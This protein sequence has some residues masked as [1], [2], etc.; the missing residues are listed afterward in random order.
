M[1]GGAKDLCARALKAARSAGAGEAA[2][3]LSER[4]EGH[5]RF[6]DN[7][8]TTSAEVQRSTLSLWAAAG[9]RHASGSTGDLSSAGILRLTEEVVAR[10]RMSPEDPEYVPEAPAQI[11]PPIPSFD[12]EAASMGPAAR[13]ALV[14]PVLDTAVQGSLVAAGLLRDEIVEEMRLSTTGSSGSRR[15]TR[16]ELSATLRRRD[17]SASGWAGAAGVRLS[18]VD[19]H[20]IAARAAQKASAWREPRELPPGPYTVVLEP[21]A[22]GPLF[23]AL[24]MSLD[25]RSAEE[26][27]SAFS[28]PGGKSRVGEALFSPAVTLVSD[29]QDPMVPGTPWSEGGLAARRVGYVQAGVLRELQRSRYWA[30]RTGISPTAD[31]GTL[32]L[33]GGGLSL[34]ELVGKVDRGLLVTRI[35]YVRML[36]P[37]RI[38]VTGLTRD[39]TF[40]IEGGRATAAVKNFRFNQSLLDLLRDVVALGR[41]EAALGGELSG[42]MALPPV[43]V[44]DFHMSSVSEAV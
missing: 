33:V 2:T 11:Y 39:A 18:D 29:P 25:A 9:L 32:R 30:R 22:L 42:G 6:A 19:P 16:V 44:K 31:G 36:D 8:P 12:A 1:R 4:R 17:G 34:E 38:G 20:R 15:A 35:W 10:A 21:G 3:L 5:L 23:P 43:L 14:K 24:R 41:E 26:G 37:Q 27:R 28:A 13:A 7:G 40:L